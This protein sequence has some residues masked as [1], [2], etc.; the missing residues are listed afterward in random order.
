[1][2]SPRIRLVGQVTRLGF[3][4]QAPDDAFFATTLSDAIKSVADVFAGFGKCTVGSQ[5]P[6]QMV[7][8]GA[9]AVAGK[10]VII[11]TPNKKIGLRLAQSLL[12]LDDKATM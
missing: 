12:S 11:S 9:A 1:M 6:I 7:F 10:S 4:I 8:D 3:E 5:K 2:P